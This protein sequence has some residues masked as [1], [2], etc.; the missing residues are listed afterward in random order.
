[1]TRNLSSIPAGREEVR[2]AVPRA[3]LPPRGGVGNM[4]STKEEN[5]YK[6]LGILLTGLLV[7]VSCLAQGSLIGTYKLVSMRAEIDGKVRDDRTKPPHGYLIIT[8]RKSTRL[9]S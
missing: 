1:M 4:N 8:D 7:S 3:A 2:S 9:N 6:S 5:M